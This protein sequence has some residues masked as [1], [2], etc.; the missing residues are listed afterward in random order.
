MQVLDTIPTLSPISDACQIPCIAGV[1]QKG[2]NETQFSMDFLI[3]SGNAVKS[4]L[5]FAA[6]SLPLMETDMKM[7]QMIPQ[8]DLDEPSLKVLRVLS[9]EGHHILVNYCTASSAAAASTGIKTSA[10]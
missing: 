6:A 1:D 5:T 9:C 3:G 4:Y 7:S 10:I 8:A 2:P